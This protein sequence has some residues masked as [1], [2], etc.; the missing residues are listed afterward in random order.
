MKK[1]FVAF[2]CLLLIS[3]S[4]S[5]DDPSDHNIF[6]NGHKVPSFSFT[7]LDGTTA[8]IDDYKGK[9]ILLNFFSTWC[10]PCM[11]GLP[12]I[13]EQIQDG[14]DNDNLVVLAFGRG[15]D[16]KELTE[17]NA[18]HK[19][20]FLICPDDDQ[21]TYEIFFSKYIPRNV[22]ISKN[23]KII[24]QECGYSEKGFQ[25]IIDTIKKDLEN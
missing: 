25:R 4:C 22:V 8:N 2:C 23:G 17:W 9:T 12:V 5:L 3:F 20:T 10:S 11:K 24:L 7:T 15:H 14:I 1:H 18:T 13:Q 16:A 6:E 21:S 19:F